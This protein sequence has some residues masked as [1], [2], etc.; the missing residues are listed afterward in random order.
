[1]LENTMQRAMDN[2][3]KGTERTQNVCLSSLDAMVSLHPVTIAIAI[4]TTGW[5]KRVLAVP[6]GASERPAKQHS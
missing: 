6:H 5:S 4:H 3:S 1:M 2:L